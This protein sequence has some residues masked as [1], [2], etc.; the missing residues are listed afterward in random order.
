MAHVRIRGKGGMCGAADTSFLLN[1]YFAYKCLNLG[2]GYSAFPEI[3]C[4]IVVVF[5]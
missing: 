3:G 4:Q 2:N 1:A 5:S